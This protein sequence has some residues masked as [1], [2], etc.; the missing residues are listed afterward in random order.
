ML[1][2][3]P[4][5]LQ[6]L[7]QAL[8]Q[9]WL[10]ASLWLWTHGAEHGVAGSAVTWR[11]LCNLPLQAMGHQEGRARALAGWSPYLR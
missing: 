2:R 8:G 7:L 5:S 9:E 11:W 6:R 3:P 4:A 10:A 1:P